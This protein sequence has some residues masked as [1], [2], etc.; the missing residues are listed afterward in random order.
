MTADPRGL[1]PG[2][3]G[4]R[5]VVLALFCGGFATFAQLYCYQAVLPLISREE[6]VSVPG[7]ALSV[8][9][10]A[11]GIALAALPWAIVSS[12]LG[13]V[14]VMR[15]ALVASATVG[16]VTALLPTWELVLAGRVV[17]GLFLSA[18]PVLA[19]T[20]VTEEVHVAS[21]PRVVGTFIAGNTLGALAARLIAATVG[22]LAGWR[23]GVLTVAG[24]CLLACLG[25]LRSVP[26][27]HGFRGSHGGEAATVLKALRPVLLRPAM[28]A[29][30]A[31]PFLL[32]GVMAATFNYVAYRL[33][34]EPFALPT[35]VT[36][37]IFL[38]Y[39]AGTVSSRLAGGLIVRHGYRRTL[40]AGTVV[41]GAGLVLTLPDHLAA[42]AVGMVA[43]TVGY[44]L[45]SPV[46]HLL[47]AHLA[48]TASRAAAT[49]MYQVAYYVGVFALGWQLGT[50][51]DG[52]GWN[53]LVTTAL[54]LL[55][56]ALVAGW[57]GTRGAGQRPGGVGT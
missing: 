56:G 25:F 22:D 41:M 8:S 27:P 48:P 18:L 24:M 49:A 38:V 44:F 30:Y 16:I 47:A 46:S 50:V 1:T 9:L 40:A 17:S 10:A 57:T 29:V 5:R 26:E 11:A 2:D 34:A 45:T 15:V 7:A 37:L 35:S 55:A 6:E 51:Y 54:V 43:I 53:G 39:L 33:S 13:R 28:L 52:A 3:A 12:R 36:S 42:V 14:R 21:A 4:H 31:Q 23:A 20:Y 32:M 19:V